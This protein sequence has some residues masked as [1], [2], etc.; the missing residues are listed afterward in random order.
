MLN[1]RATNQKSL[2][3]GSVDM[4]AT[5][6]LLA[7]FD[8]QGQ[9]TSARRHGMAHACSTTRRAVC[10]RRSGSAVAENTGILRMNTG[11]LEL[12][13]TFEKS[14]FDNRGGVSPK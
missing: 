2:L 1:L 13:Y 11:I 14:S 12:R 9:A 3:C 4:T 8:G 6:G 10:A 5:W 7:A